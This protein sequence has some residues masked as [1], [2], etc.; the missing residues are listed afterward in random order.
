MLFR[1]SDSAENG[2]KEA[3]LWFKPEEI[4]SWSRDVDKWIFEK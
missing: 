4:V 2:E 3:A 1:S